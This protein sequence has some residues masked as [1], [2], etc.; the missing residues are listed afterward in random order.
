[1]S[2]YVTSERISDAWVQALGKVNSSQG[3]TATHLMVVVSA[4]DLG[5]DPVVTEVVN[6]ALVTNGSHSVSTVANTLFPAALY[7]DPG[8]A[9]SPGLPPDAEATLDSAATELYEAYLEALPALRRVPANRSGTYFSRMISWP[10]KTATGTN[11]LQRQLM[12]FGLITG[13]GAGPR[14]PVILPSLENRM[15]PTIRAQ[16]GRWR[17][18]LSRTHVLRGSRAWFTS[19]SVCGVAPSRFSRSTGTG[20]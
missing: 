19:I 8:F 2:A 12:H 6:R 13:R 1:M 20:I 17:N 16:E 10:G 9:W 7:N 18:M 11:Q 15:A 5:V 3:G 4:P 14:M